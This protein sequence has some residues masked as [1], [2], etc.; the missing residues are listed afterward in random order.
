MI[1][2]DLVKIKCTDNLTVDYIETELKKQDIEPLRWAIVGIE[3]NE[4]LINIAYERV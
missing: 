3:N 4:Y 2:S 1:L